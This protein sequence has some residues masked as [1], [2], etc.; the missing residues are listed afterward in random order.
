MF[1]DL[2]LTLYRTQTC[3]KAKSVV[4]C[5]SLSAEGCRCVELES[6][7]LELSEPNSLQ[8]PN[9]KNKVIVPRLVTSRF[10]VRTLCPHVNLPG[11]SVI[12]RIS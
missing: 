2:S 9:I 6:Q 5:L 4:L 1:T 3:A 7:G 8:T 11:L 12:H 10:K